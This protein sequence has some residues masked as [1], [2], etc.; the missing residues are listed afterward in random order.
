MLGSGL[1][2]LGGAHIMVL[3]VRA[4]LA[5]FLALAQQGT[6]GQQDVQLPEGVSSAQFSWLRELARAGDQAKTDRL[7][8]AHP[9][10]RT[11]AFFERVCKAF[12][13]SDPG[14]AV[15][16]LP[17]TNGLLTLAEH[18]VYPEP[19][20]H[21]FPTDRHYSLAYAHF[22]VGG[23]AA[24]ARDLGPAELHYRTAIS[25]FRGRAAAG[26]QESLRD[27]GS[28]ANELFGIPA[29]Q[30]A[31]MCQLNLGT[32][33][34]DSGE[35]PKALQAFE[36]ALATLTACNDLTHA[37]M[38]HVDLSDV[39]MNL[40]NTSRAISELEAARAQCEALKDDSGV[41]QA[42]LNLG[43]L[44][45]RT[46]KYE[47]ALAQFKLA[48]KVF[49]ASGDFLNL[50][51]AI[52]GEGA[53]YLNLGRFQ[54][55]CASFERARAISEKQNDLFG[56]ARA[57]MN[58]G[59][60][61]YS[62]QRP[63][64]AIVYFESARQTA[65]AAPD[66][67]TAASCLSNLGT[68]YQELG[69][70]AEAIPCLEESLKYLRSSGMIQELASTQ[71]SIGLALGLEGRRPQAIQ[72]H[73]QALKTFGEL[74]AQKEAGVCHLNIAQLYFDQGSLAK[75]QEHLAAA[76]TALS[77]TEAAPDI[78]R[79][80]L[81]AGLLAANADLNGALAQVGS[82]VRVFDELGMPLDFL[83]A[84]MHLGD[85]YARAGDRKGSLQ[86]YDSALDKLNELQTAQSDPLSSTLSDVGSSLLA[87]YIESSK[88]DVS[89]EAAFAACQRTKGG[90][91]R[92]SLLQES[93]LEVAVGA[94]DAKRVREL[95]SE[96]ERLEKELQKKPSDASLTEARGRAFAAMNAFDLYLRTKYPS[97]RALYSSPATLSEICRALGPNDASVEYICG[98]ERI[99][100]FVARML[101][102]IPIVTRFD[103]GPS[104]TAKTATA[105]FSLQL[106]RATPN[107]QALRLLGKRLYARLVQPLQGSLKGITGLVICPDRYLHE[108]PFGAL[109]GP[110]GRY[111]IE[112]NAIAVAPSASSW[113]A[114]RVVAEAR[115]R[116]RPGAPLVVGISRFG[117]SP[118]SALPRLPR[119][120]RSGGSLDALPAAAQEAKSVAQILGCQPILESNATTSVVTKRLESAGILHFATHACGN[121]LA[122]LMG[123][124]V[125]APETK[126]E[127]GYLYARDIYRTRTKAR[128]AVLS[129]CSTLG[130]KS[131]GEGILGLSWAFL[132]A[133]CPSTIATRW[134]LDD[135]AAKLWVD[136]FYKSYAKGTPA[137]DSA[138]E[139]CLKLIR[140][141]GQKLDRS[142]PA[143][144]AAWALVGDSR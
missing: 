112:A 84:S 96:C 48:H 122:P 61:K 54:D 104:S 35:L 94:Q 25:L 134:D 27:A 40:G 111:V 47:L 57:T 69:M 2:P 113:Q 67:I 109:V 59:A 19:S 28:S 91:L 33:F 108:L 60:A 139:A 95:R 5:L 126:D 99:Y 125:L 44:Y 29:E 73:L 26:L 90:L 63:L 87:K 46:S 76:R 43:N 129:A 118:T 127:L 14:T 36:E 81:L 89:P 107:A 49:E 93:S 97:F 38:A 37:A 65:L 128:L 12:D 34:R 15:N 140:T 102:G 32:V 39:L 123:Y 3:C 18:V 75:A 13:T 45:I 141:R 77:A 52:S 16:W 103:L 30:L 115:R 56:V 82:A 114:C 6:S 83:K 136:A 31:G 100:A 22:K 55:A 143:F 110:D 68:C 78:A 4:G 70:T 71:T 7:I 92:A 144:W 11:L 131:S 23:I 132:V 119:S 51:S 120:I 105:E 116:E 130:T 58:L 101:N 74:K 137:A 85:L 79:V 53:A 64:E 80:D 24:S 9:D 124:L 8:E 41:A 121:S 1:V 17:A 106:K 42:E 98:D 50:A 66:E 135:A 10:W 86:S 133:G 142:S 117:R 20:R 72:V 62:M 138:R 88:R 21:V